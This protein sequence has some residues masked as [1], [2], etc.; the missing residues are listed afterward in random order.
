MKP[1]IKRCVKRKNDNG[2]EGVMCGVGV[3]RAVGCGG[4]WRGS[5]WGL[6]RMLRETCNEEDCCVKK[7]R[8]SRTREGRKEKRVA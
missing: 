3:V 2:R 5:G 1:K 7:G 8:D 6:V 4:L